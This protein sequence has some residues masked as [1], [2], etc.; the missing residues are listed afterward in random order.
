MG[1][2]LKEKGPEGLAEAKRA[3][4]RATALRPDFAI[5]HGNLASCLYDEG[6]LK[7]A[8]RQYKHALQ[9]SRISQMLIIIWGMR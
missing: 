4:K 8:I 3:Y 1:N 9:L 5:A 7:S 6:D 2:A